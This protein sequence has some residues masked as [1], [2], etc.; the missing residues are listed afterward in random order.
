MD[1]DEVNVVF[2]I[3][4]LCQITAIWEIS[5]WM[6][7]EETTHTLSEIPLST[8]Q[9]STYLHATYY[10]LL[11]FHVKN[12][13]WCFGNHLGWTLL[14]IEISFSCYRFT[15]CVCGSSVFRGACEAQENTSP[16]GNIY[17]ERLPALSGLTKQNVTNC[18]CPGTVKYQAA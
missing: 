15:D 10:M 11:H 7:F 12:F 2:Q 18:W 3:K 5:Y 8:D 1:F 16:E 6:R 13:G 4:S 9:D 17:S 14:E